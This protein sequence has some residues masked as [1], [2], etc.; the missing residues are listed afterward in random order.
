MAQ[1]PARNATSAL[2]L[3]GGEFSALGTYRVSERSLSDN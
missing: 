1:R 3:A 2:E